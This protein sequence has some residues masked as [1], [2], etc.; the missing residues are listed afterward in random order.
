M[1]ML[2]VSYF[3]VAMG[4]QRPLR[5]HESR[6]P[7]RWEREVPALVVDAGRGMKVQTQIDD[8]FASFPEQKEVEIPPFISPPAR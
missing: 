7:Q 3:D 5:G 6:T 2:D 4:R 1:T 8:G